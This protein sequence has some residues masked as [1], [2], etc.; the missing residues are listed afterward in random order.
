MPQEFAI[1]LEW[2]LAVGGDHATHRDVLF[3]DPLAGGMT[4]VPGTLGQL[5]RNA[6]SERLAQ[7]SI[8]PLVAAPGSSF[9]EHGRQVWV[10]KMQPAQKAELLLPQLLGE[11]GRGVKLGEQII[12]LGQ[13]VASGV[14]PLAQDPPGFVQVTVNLFE[15]GFKPISQPVTILGGH[16]VVFA[17]R[18]H[19]LLIT[20]RVG[21]AF[22]HAGDTRTNFFG[23]R[24]R[25]FGQ[26]AATAVSIALI[27]NP[28]VCSNKN[29]RS[30]LRYATKS[31]TSSGVKRGFISGID[32]TGPYPSATSPCG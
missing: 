8:G 16:P 19:G 30:V 25:M 28:V 1:G 17:E 12:A 10:I 13:V 2:S 29:Q 5:G 20:V 15:R 22:G 14:G 18:R 31:R 24:L 6:G 21:P 27:V 9:C 23:V 3:A 7:S 32:E 26:T 4:N 11:V